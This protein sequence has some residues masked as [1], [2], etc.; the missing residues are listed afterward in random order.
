ME[1][2]SRFSMYAGEAESQRRRFV[3]ARPWNWLPPPSQGS[4]EGQIFL[5]GEVDIEAL[6]VELVV[7]VEV[8]EGG[9]A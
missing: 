8:D 5:A 9:H 3:G 4:S 6:T 2:P 1:S 7:T